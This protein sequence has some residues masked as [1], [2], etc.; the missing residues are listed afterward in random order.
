[1][2]FLGH[3]YLSGNDPLV[4]VGN[5][6][7]DAVK[8]RDLDRFP[9]GIQKG[10]R[11]HRAIDSFTD[12]HPL[13]LKGK[14]RARPHSG[15]YAAV[16]MDIFY[17]HLLAVRWME[18]RN[19]PLSDFTRRTYALLSGHQHLLPDRT[20]HMLPYMI[21]GDW[22]GSY[23]TMEGIGRALSG[24][25]KRVNNGA[26]MSGAETILAENLEV[27]GSEFELFLPDLEKHVEPLL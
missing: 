22:L 17:D 21:G 1:M 6:M 15:R 13:V 18:R 12:Q 5:F 26:A 10:I 9:S 16:V 27:Y 2:N 14:E 11:L 8:G 25:A 4:T 20:R 19:E 23:A 7:A 24:L 3:L